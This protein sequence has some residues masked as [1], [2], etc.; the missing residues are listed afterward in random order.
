VQVEGGYYLGAPSDEEST[1]EFVAEAGI[2]QKV[3]PYRFWVNTFSLYRG[4]MPIDRKKKNS[5]KPLPTLRRPF[6][7]Y[8]ES[9][10][11]HT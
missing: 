1:L 7:L 3:W 10:P 4:S 6:S 2:S 5:E 9:M 8:P 11:V